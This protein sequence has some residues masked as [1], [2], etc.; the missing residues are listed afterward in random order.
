M[1]Y[2]IFLSHTAADADLVADVKRA[3]KALDMEVYAYEDDLHAGANVGDKLLREIDACDALVALLTK[4]GS[5]RHAITLEVGCALKAGKPIIAIVEDGVDF[6]GYTLLQGREYVPL[7]R[8]KP[9]N[10][11]LAVQEALKKHRSDQLSEAI[12]FGAMVV[13][14]FI[15][16]R[17]LGEG[18]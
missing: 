4:A 7:D 18:K 8:A 11:L 10:A 1:P 17:A 15:A 5:Q 9:Q 12:A 16:I 14:A 13:L 6:Q 3:A 2:R